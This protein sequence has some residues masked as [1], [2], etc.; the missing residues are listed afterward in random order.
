MLI[1]FLDGCNLWILVLLSM[2]R[3]YML[4]Q[5]LGC[6]KRN[7]IKHFDHEAGGIYFRNADISHIHTV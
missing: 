3:R 4:P 5:T 6:F 1:P 7:R 2:F